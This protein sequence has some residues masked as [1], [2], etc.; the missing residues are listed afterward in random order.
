M[1][2]KVYKA[3][4]NELNF[5]GIHGSYRRYLLAALFASGI[6]GGL[7]GVATSMLVGVLLFILLAGMGY[8][9]IVVLQEK[10]DYRTLQRLFKSRKF[11]LYIYLREPLRRLWK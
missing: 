6:I 5:F 8:I 1:R 4:D 7:A 11:P 2:R 3:M 10:Y 9:G